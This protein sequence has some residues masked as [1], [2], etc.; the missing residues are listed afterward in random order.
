MTTISAT[1]AVLVT[2]ATGLIGRHTH[3]PLVKAG[4][5]VHAVA[6][7]VPDLR[8]KGVVWHGGDL[9][10]RGFR[11]H[12]ID[13]AKP[14]H[15]LHLAWVT[16]HGR[17]WEAPD[18]DDWLEASRDLLTRFAGQGGRRAVVAGT[19]A[20]Y[21]WSPTALGRGV[22]GEVATPALPATLYGRAKLALGRLAADICPSAASGRVFLTF[23]EGEDSRRLVPAIADALIAGR[24]VDLGPGDRVRDFI[25]AR[26]LAAA[27][28]ALTTA[29]V[30]G[31]INLASGEGRRI[32]S[33]ART[34]A[35]L[36]GAPADLLRFG[37]RPAPPGEPE[38]LVADVT[39]M[40]RELGFEP[41]RD[42]RA[43]LADY[44]ARRRGTV[45][46]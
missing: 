45:G 23:G 44:V 40:T 25:A 2:G 3:V 12:L 36:I 42:L 37:A 20:E 6:R 32:E 15:L 39:R 30:E 21:D 33:V 14:S 35:E 11:T 7:R 16:E 8:R 41:A 26:E 5:V 27:F 19:C 24:P 38:K 28:A 4:L 13:V 1:G 10:D 31:A 22:A 29:S 18:N 34:I 46:R 9:L 43:G 17:F